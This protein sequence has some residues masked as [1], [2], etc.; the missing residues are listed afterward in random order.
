MQLAAVA[1]IAAALAPAA[2]AIPAG[3]TTATGSSVS[4]RVPAYDLDLSRSNDVQTLYTRLQRAAKQ[5]CGSAGDQRN[6]SASEG[7]R[8][9][10]Y[11]ALRNAV[12]SVDNPEL[13]NMHSG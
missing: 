9:C 7:W 6:I 3:T 4:V 11:N 1:L 8:K 10:Y 13:N 5:V 12:E 2:G